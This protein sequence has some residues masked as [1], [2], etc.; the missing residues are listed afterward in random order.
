MKNILYSETE[1]YVKAEN[2]NITFTERHQPYHEFSKVESDFFIPKKA[3]EVMNKLK[4]F[5]FLDEPENRIH[6]SEQN[7]AARSRTSFSIEFTKNNLLTFCLM[8]ST[9]QQTFWANNINNSTNTKMDRFFYEQVVRF[10]KFNFIPENGWGFMYYLDFRTLREYNWT[11]K[12]IKDLDKLKTLGFPMNIIPFLLERDYSTETMES[13]IGLPTL[14]I[15]KIV[16]TANNS[17]E[18]EYRNN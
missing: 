7:E 8:V 4:V 1:G 12:Q 17:P 2:F 6:F 14:W 13:F 5:G 18:K 3:L 9:A 15:R 16:N 10:N 11:E